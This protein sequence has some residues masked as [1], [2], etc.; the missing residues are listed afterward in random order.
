MQCYVL[1]R[2]P[3][4]PSSTYSSSILILRAYSSSSTP[5]PIKS[6]NTPRPPNTPSPPGL[7]NANFE[8]SVLAND[9]STFSKLPKEFGANQHLVIDQEVK[10]RL[11]SVLW[12]FNAPIRYAFAYGSG[13]FNQGGYA[14]DA[15]PMVDFIFGV[16]HAQH[17][18]SLNIARHPEHYSGLR[19]LG[20]AAISYIQR[21]FGGKVY[22][23]PYVEV[24]GMM[25]KYGVVSIDDLC[26]D[27]NGWE[28]MYLAGRMQKPIK[29]LRDEPRVRLANQINLI[30]ALRTALLLLPE[31]FTEKELYETIAGLSYMGDARMRVAENPKKVQNIVSAQLPKFR[32]LYGPLVENLPNLTFQSTV[33]MQST[34]AYATLHQ[35][36]DP[37]RR[38][39]M[40]GRLPLH[41]RTKIQ[42]IFLKHYDMKYLPQEREGMR[43]FEERIVGDERLRREIGRA[44]RKT[45]GWSSG[46]Q[47]VKGLFSAGPIKSWRYVAEK[48]GKKTKKE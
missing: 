39:K 12:Q 37:V 3:R 41:F 17:F 48:V 45:V 36:L 22:F 47:T 11:R 32:E 46:V 44:V 21:G 40:V 23:N 4:V 8:E 13:V 35:D 38:A 16:T 5:E 31:K 28:T 30:S 25:I 14:K 15:K 43:M 29:I 2:F 6:R 26:A 18:H 42:S 20:S 19:H 34:D 9:V 27:L 24:N 1:P 7:S 10:E 33:P